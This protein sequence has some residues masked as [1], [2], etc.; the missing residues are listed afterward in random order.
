M[1]E[2]YVQT[3]AD[4]EK[5]R[6]APLADERRH[7]LVHLRAQGYSY[8]RVRRINNVLLAIAIRLKWGNQKRISCAELSAAADRW[9]AQRTRPGTRPRS[10]QGARTGF[11]SVGSAWLRHLGRLEEVPIQVPFAEQF[12]AFLLHL[13]DERGL[14]DNTLICRRRSLAHFFGW[15]SERGI[16]IGT[17]GPREI[18]EYFSAHRIRPW[19]RATVSFHVYTL[20]SFFRYAASRSWCD[21]GIPAMI[22]KPRQYSQEGLPEGPRWADV[23]RLIASLN[24]SHPTQVRSR[25]IILLLAIYGFR[26]GEVCRLRL[27]DIDWRAERIYLHRPKQRKT[28]E[29]PLIA[30]VGEALL[31]YIREV[32]PR[33]AHREIF[34]TLK[35]PYHPPCAAGLGTIV[36]THI[37]NLGVRLPH[38]GPHVL[39]HACAR[40]LLAAGFSLKEIGDHLGHKSSEATK[41]YAKVDLPS[42]RQATGEISAL[43]QYAAQCQREATPFFPKGSLAA[44][45]EVARFHLGGVQ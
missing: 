20:R 24:G 35:Q 9:I 40:H 17:V 22:D 38:Y 37:K 14:A 33:S 15:L 21:E 19:K 28:Q 26:I 34:L 41:I 23:Q 3:A 42:L 13:R 7:F 31:R 1:F 10:I 18:T 44:L 39:R 12:G 4:L 27:D 2:E 32:R 43:A 6:N 36:I 25:A 30:T 16:S 29:Y 8:S 5:Y 45:R 11:I